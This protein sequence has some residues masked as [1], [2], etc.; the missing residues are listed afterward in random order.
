MPTRTQCS[1]GGGASTH[2]ADAPPP[3]PG[4]GPA[5]RR[6]IQSSLGAGGA[7]PGFLIMPELAA[8]STCAAEAGVQLARVLL[9]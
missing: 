6:D 8:W 7:A 1:G 4:A 2:P 3:P 9:V 5:Q